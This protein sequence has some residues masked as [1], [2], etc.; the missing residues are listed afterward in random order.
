MKCMLL[1]SFVMKYCRGTFSIAEAAVDAAVLY[2]Q[3][4]SS[5]GLCPMFYYHRLFLLPQFVQREFLNW[6]GAT[7]SP[8]QCSMFS[9]F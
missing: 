1:E 2:S 7:F 8:W 3:H 9:Y 6:R 4:M 5:N